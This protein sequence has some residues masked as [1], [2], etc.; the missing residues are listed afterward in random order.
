MDGGNVWTAKEDPDRPGAEWSS[1]FYK[2]IALGTGVG[3]R[4]DFEYFKLALDL[5]YRVRNPFPNPAGSYWA[6]DRWRELG[7]KG[8]NY[9]L[10]VGYPF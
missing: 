6:Y 8:I 4:M 10:A 3:F 7:L 2:Q 9:N 1:D 5:G